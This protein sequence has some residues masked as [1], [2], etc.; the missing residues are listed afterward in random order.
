MYFANASSD[1]LQK[2]NPVFEIVMVVLCLLTSGMWFW[3]YTL[4]HRKT[5]T[6][7][8]RKQLQVTLTPLGVGMMFIL[9]FLLLN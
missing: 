3:H 5:N 7:W 8:T 6:G 1:A 2:A 9:I 4:H